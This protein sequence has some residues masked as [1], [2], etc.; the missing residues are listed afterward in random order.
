[1]TRNYLVFGAGALGSFIGGGLSKN[2]RLSV[3]LVGRENHTAS[4]NRTGLEVT[5]KSGETETFKRLKAVT[6]I[7]GVEKPDV[8]ILSTRVYQNKRALRDITSKFGKEVLILTFQN[9]NPL[10]SISEFVGKSNVIGGTTILSAE[11]TKSGAVKQ[12]FVGPFIIGELDGSV[13]R[14]ISQI[15]D[16]FKDAGLECVISPNIIGEIWAKL[17]INGTNNTLSAVLNQG[18]RTL[19]ASQKYRKYCYAILTET[20]AVAK[21]EN[22]D[23][24]NVS[25]GVAS[26]MKE[27]IKSDSN[28]KKFADFKGE[29]LP[30]IQLSMASQLKNGVK[31]EVDFING[32]IASRAKAHG[33]KTPMHDALIKAV[34]AIEGGKMKP[35]EN[36]LSKFD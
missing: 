17:I 25:P 7:T 22:I 20:F 35:N 4:I 14:R 24:E 18:I 5:F 29:T 6:K 26:Q 31:S 2:T 19:Y 1:M 8:V 27:A 23:L 36:I 9:G 10:P 13:S 11:L 16:D 30:D 21:L 12:T 3:T 34:H 28:F 33:Y 15:R 32:Y